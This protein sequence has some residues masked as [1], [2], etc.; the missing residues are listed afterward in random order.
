[1]KINLSFSV[2][3]IVDAVL[4]QGSIDM[5]VYNSETMQEGTR[6]HAMIQSSHANPSYNAEYFLSTTYEL[7]DFVL[8]ISGRADGFIREPD[9]KITIDEIKT[10]V[11]DLEK[12]KE[13]NFLWHQGQA[14]MYAWMYLR[15]QEGEGQNTITV[16]VSYYRQHHRK[17]ILVVDEEFTF[18]QLDRF[19]TE[20]IGEFVERLRAVARHVVDRNASLRYLEFPY[21][22]YRSGQRDLIAFC[23]RILMQKG[24]GYALAPTGIGKTVCVLYPFVRQL[25]KDTSIRKIFYLTSKNSIKRQA[26]RT[27]G[28][29]IEKGA[30]LRCVAITAKETICMNEPGFKKHCNPDECPFAVNYYSKIYN[31]L[32]EALSQKRI[33][34]ADD[35]KNIAERYTICPFQLSLDLASY[36]DICIYDYNYVF[37]P[38]VGNPEIRDTNIPLNDLLLI[39]ETHNLPSRARGMYSASISMDMLLEGYSQMKGRKLAKVKSAIL[40]ILDWFDRR[41]Y[42]QDIEILKE[43]P[44]DFITLL[45]GFQDECLS[46]ERKEHPILPDS[47][48]SI[49]S[50]VRAFLLLPYQGRQNYCYDVTY[51]DGKATEISIRCLDAS[52]YIKSITDRFVST[53]FFSATLSPTDYYISLLGGDVENDPLQNLLVLPSPFEKKNRLVMVN[54]SPSLKYG[55]RDNSFS[56]VLNSIYQMTRGC[57][58]NYFLFFPSYSYMMKAYEKFEELGEFVCHRQERNMTPSERN[59]FLDGFEEDPLRTHLG[60]L[61]LGGM[62][63]EGI[64]LRRHALKGVAIVSVGI[65]GVGYDNETLKEYYSGIGMDG[66]SYAYTYP[67]FNKVVQACG[68]LIRNDDD[69]GVILLIDKRFS[70]ATYRKLLDEVYPDR[71]EVR[72]PQEI[73]ESVASFWKENG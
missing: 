8:D 71:I 14:K 30:D 47:Y 65:P 45:K 43:I 70:F 63:S 46:M 7:E 21:G 53:V 12:F 20:L 17:D 56:S 59:E 15:G 67:G 39:D 35:I 31:A 5:R 11:S 68:R 44:L 24:K 69:K 57:V 2:H 9:G 18:E 58:G 19:A 3:D 22:S 50:V 49:K 41:S 1:M 48:L 72:S 62:F 37:D 55:D 28:E 26:L 13:E 36:C 6:M 4:R 73:G 29:F 64:E 51:K 34:D 10:T 38:V 25:E 54:S 27:V 60:F 23:E 61:V 32:R 16:R 52:R 40:S 66:F 42:Q 33:F